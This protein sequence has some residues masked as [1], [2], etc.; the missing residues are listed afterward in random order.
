MR[1]EQTKVTSASKMNARWSGGMLG[2]LWKEALLDVV[3]DRKR[4]RLAINGPLPPMIYFFVE[5]AS[6][7]YFARYGLVATEARALALGSHDFVDVFI[8]DGSLRHAAL[9]L[10]PDAEDGKHLQLIDLRS[11]DGMK[12][13]GHDVEGQLEA[14]KIIQVALGATNAT[15]ILLHD[16]E[17]ALLNF[18]TLQEL[19]AEEDYLR[20][21]VRKIYE[22]LDEKLNVDMLPRKHLQ[23][24]HH[25]DDDVGEEP[26]P[27][28]EPQIEEKN[29]SKT[30]SVMERSSVVSSYSKVIDLSK[31]NRTMV[32]S[33]HL[34][35]NDDDD[36]KVW[37]KAYLR[38]SRSDF[39][40]GALIGRYERCMTSSISMHEDD[41]LSR[42][43]ALVVEKWGKLWLLDA[44]STNGT[45]VFDVASGEILAE[46][47]D[48]LRLWPLQDNEGIRVGAHETIFVLPDDEMS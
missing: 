25:I 20:T 27:I 23:I 10:W 47:G 36:E 28:V 26:E 14:K 44:G 19:T 13:W 18:N 34:N 6:Q 24:V 46:L 40:Q 16:D 21:P 11:V 22:D 43:H 37:Q 17:D 9:L 2:A 38:V 39:V 30:S 42:V 7:H 29:V 8:P 4:S 48:G 3:T 12:V 33:V 45:L 32:T 35:D 1:R 15:C 31:P 41:K 5:N